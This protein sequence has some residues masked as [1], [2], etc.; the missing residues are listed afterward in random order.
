MQRLTRRL[1]FVLAVLAL[2]APLAAQ[3]PE[4]IP[5]AVVFGNPEKASPQISPDG[6]FLAYLAP[7]KG[8][9]NVWVR[10][11]GKDDDH[12]VTRDR[13]RGIRTFYWAE[14]S[15]NVLYI[16]DRD[17]DENWHL[18]AAHLKTSAIR[19]LSPFE[20]IRVQGIYSDSKVPDQLL[21]GMNLRDQSVF[22][23][24]R[25]N[26]RNG[27][28]EPEAQS[29][30]N[31]VSWVID[32]DLRVRGAVAATEEGGYQLLVGKEPG[33]AFEVFLSWGPEDN[34]EPHGFTPDG[35]GLYIEDNLESDTTELYAIDIATKKKTVLA[36]N[37]EVDVW[38]V[39]T[40]PLRHNVQAVGFNLH[41]LEWTVLDQSVAADFE[42]LRKVQPG[43]FSIINR[44]NA[45]RTWLISYV[46][47]TQPVHYYAYDRET[48]K[49]TFLFTARPALEK[50]QLA[51]MKPVTIPARDGLK[52][53]SYLT[54]PLG[55]EAKNLPLV[56]N[57][58]G[59]PWGRD[60]WGYNGEAQWLANRG[61]AVL[62]VNF[63]ASAG[64][65]KKFL[66][67]GN[68]EWGAKMHDDLIDAVNWAIHE[69]LADPKQIC[70]YGG[71]Y[72]GYAALAGAAFT[73]DVFHCS[74]DIV[75]PSN[76]VTLLKS[77]PPYWKAGLNEFHNRIG[78]EE[79]EV[80]FLHSRSPLFKADQIKIPLL[81]A[82][83]ANDP[84]VKQAESEQIVEALRKKGKDVEYLVFPDEGHGFARPEN[85]MAFYAAAEQF[86]AK[87][88]GGRSEPP[89]EAEAKLLAG[90]RQAEKKATGGN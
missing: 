26:L 13:K 12:V 37:P 47:D 31:Y 42:A 51:P 57:V 63:R 78:N 69:G 79:T 85:R 25:V 7:D 24:Y 89:S 32:N 72:G 52:L 81:I 1:V 9:L 76:L 38:S 28:V 4:L 39:L 82:Q 67:A 36:H 2:A 29:E 33:A 77:I 73:P 50:Y 90:V 84:R 64:F 3:P 65:G 14:D 54:L 44:D 11:I 56:L 58:H 60:A 5:R 15:Q 83:G 53:V 74:V 43:Q 75:G 23:L 21:M 66:N 6:A 45:D 19:D 35:K 18:Y 86:L 87:Y 10:T 27:A 17:G 71:S 16:Q 20:G 70:I 59:G 62:Q 48:K 88:L 49:A 40:H 8:V 22:D 61:Y 46:V 41:R 68:R 55:R 34:G 30:P 80:E